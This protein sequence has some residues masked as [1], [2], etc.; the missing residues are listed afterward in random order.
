MD[1]QTPLP[2]PSFRPTIFPLLFIGGGSKVKEGNSNPEDENVQHWDLP[3]FIWR[4]ALKRRK[5]MKIRWTLLTDGWSG[6]DHPCERDLNTVRTT[7]HRSIKSWG[8][9]C[10]CGRYD[11]TGVSSGPVLMSGFMNWIFIGSA[12]SYVF[13][14]YYADPW[15]SAFPTARQEKTHSGTDHTIV[16][17]SSSAKRNEIW[18]GSTIVQCLSS[19]LDSYFHRSWIQH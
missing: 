3:S 7:H 4:W 5:E 15:S 18:A 12:Q 2:F 14:L 10:L 19:S 11:L 9:I 13:F 17:W 1:G 8:S 16:S 6:P